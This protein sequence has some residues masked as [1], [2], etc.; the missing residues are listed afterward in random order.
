MSGRGSGNRS[1]LGQERWERR[2]SRAHT[3]ALPPL[4]C[5]RTGEHGV[6]KVGGRVEQ[7]S[8]GRC[9]GGAVFGER[10]GSGSIQ[11]QPGGHERRVC[12]SGGGWRGKREVRALGWGGAG[13][14]EGP[15]RAGTCRGG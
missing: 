15:G 14:S 10:G 6:A 8:A 5:A 9:L 11:L 4:L 12:Q 3:R 13:G 1:W 7:G 2:V